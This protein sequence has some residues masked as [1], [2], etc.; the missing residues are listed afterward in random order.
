MIHNQGSSIIQVYLNNLERQCDL[1]YN[2][3]F[4]YQSSKLYSFALFGIYTLI[5]V[6]FT[7]SEIFSSLILKFK[8]FP[9][10]LAYI[11]I[12]LHPMHRIFWV[13]FVVFPSLEKHNQELHFVRTI[14]HMILKITS[15]LVFGL[16]FL[17]W[18]LLN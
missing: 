14:N 10:V 17:T 15:I 12:A 5:R 9:I 7:L 4:I 13:L 6:P 1:L 8:L 3:L 18:I 2:D 16:T 11:I